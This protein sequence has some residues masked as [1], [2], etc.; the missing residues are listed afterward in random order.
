L[1]LKTWFASL[2]LVLSAAACGSDGPTQVVDPGPPPALP[3]GVQIVTAPNGLQYA[4][5]VVG[6]GATVAQVGNRVRVHYTGWLSSTNKFFDTSAGGPPLEF[7]LG[8]QAVIAGFDEGIRGMK[9]GG[10]RRLIIPPSLGYGSTAVT[11]PRTGAVVIPANST[12][13]F[14]V[15]LVTVS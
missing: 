1:K 10:K 12:L 5:V 11:D 6:T 2:A 14:D 4:D 15:Q 8:Q 13:I 3:A 7:F 9:A